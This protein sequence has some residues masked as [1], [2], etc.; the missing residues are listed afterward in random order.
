MKHLKNISDNELGELLDL[1]R[2]IQQELH[3]YRHVAEF[4]EKIQLE[5]DKFQEK[6]FK[7]HDKREENY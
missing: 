5:A 3:N 1:M 2:R 4:A 7:E 6:L